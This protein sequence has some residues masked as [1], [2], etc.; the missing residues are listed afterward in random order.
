MLPIDSQSALTTCCPLVAEHAFCFM[1]VSVHYHLHSHHS[2]VISPNNVVVWVLVSGDYHDSDDDDSDT[3]ERYYV[4]CENMH[5]DVSYND[6]K[7]LPTLGPSLLIL[8]ASVLRW[9]LVSN[10]TVLRRVELAKYVS[11]LLTYHM[12]LELRNPNPDFCLGLKSFHTG[13]S[14]PGEGLH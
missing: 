13:Y 8:A 4:F 10:F 2:P 6:A 11:W 12:C 14:C 1:G 7:W 9:K 5:F 3:V